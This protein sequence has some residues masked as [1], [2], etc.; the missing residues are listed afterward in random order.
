[1]SAASGTHSASSV[2][3]AMKG[4]PEI[5]RELTAELKRLPN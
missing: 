5:K 4:V 1:V 2:R 3:A